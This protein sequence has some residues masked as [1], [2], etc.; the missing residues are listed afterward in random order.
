ME[1]EAIKLGDS[2]N[3]QT[4]RLTI[5]VKFTDGQT[6]FTRDYSFN[7]KDSEDVIKKRIK[8]DLDE[9]NY[10]PVV[11]QNGLIDFSTVEEVIK[12]PTQEEIK[13]EQIN[14]KK[15][16]LETAYNDLQK[17]LITD[18]EYDNKVAEYKTFVNSLTSKT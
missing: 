5:T 17:K 15:A 7:L 2:I 16:E 1:F 11:F 18:T 10:T 6:E 9:I 13:T 4:Q 8:Y 14:I 12:Q 3:R